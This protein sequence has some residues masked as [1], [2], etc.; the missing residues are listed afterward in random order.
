MKKYSEEEVMQVLNLSLKNDILFNITFRDDNEL[1]KEFIE[2]LENN[3]LSNRIQVIMQSEQRVN[4]SKKSVLDMKVIDG[5]KCYVVEMQQSKKDF[6]PPRAELITSNTFSN[7]CEAGLETIDYPFV[8]LHVLCT[9]NTFNNQKYKFIVKKCVV[10]M[11]DYNYKSNIKIVYHNIA[12]NN[13]PNN[14][15]GDLCRFLYDNTLSSHSII[16]KLNEKIKK[17]KESETTFMEINQL[18]LKETV[19][20][21]RGKVEGIELGKVEGI[22]LLKESLR[23]TLISLKEKGFEKSFSCGLVKDS[24]ELPKEDIN[25]II[26]EIYN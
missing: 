21:N 1:S 14:V 6:D 4:F 25:K 5:K 12:S 22:E 11:Y 16:V 2:I 19:I 17:I 26:E 23:K 9:Y 24:F 18:L 15:Y 8:T 3:K 7:L 20:L 13:L 10:D